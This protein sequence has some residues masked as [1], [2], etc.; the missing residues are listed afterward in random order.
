MAQ[1]GSTSRGCMNFS[2]WYAG[3]TEGPDTLKANK[4]A[5]MRTKA[6]FFC[7]YFF[8]TRAELGYWLGLRSQHEHIGSAKCGASFSWQQ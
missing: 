6:V 7:S 5:L 8:T 2:S 1:Y 4:Q 3:A